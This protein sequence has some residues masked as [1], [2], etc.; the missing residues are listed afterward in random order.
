MPTY[1]QV[2]SPN[3]KS[4]NSGWR[5]KK[6]AANALAAKWHNGSKRADIAQQADDTYSTQGTCQAS[7]AHDT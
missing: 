4:S 1:F 7:E 2:M 5:E 6:P 3:S